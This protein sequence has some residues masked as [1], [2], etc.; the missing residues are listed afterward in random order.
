MRNIY[1]SVKNLHWIA[2]V[3]LA[4]LFLVFPLLIWSEIKLNSWS[5]G[6]LAQIGNFAQML[7]PIASSFWPV[8]VFHQ[9]VEGNARELIFCYRKGHLLEL[10]VY[11]AVY[12]ACMAIVFFVLSFFYES[13]WWEYLRVAIQSLFF[14]SFTYAVV[15]LIRS[16]ALGLMLS[17]LLELFFMLTRNYISSTWSIFSFDCLAK[18]D[19]FILSEQEK[20][21]KF[22]IL[23]GLSVLFWGIGYVRARKIKV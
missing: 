5:Q 13:V 2:L 20:V 18:E 4:V 11:G 12:V 8:F 22:I 9:Y 3:P 15:F 17:L 1:Y 19:V 14:L 21:D 23:L 6:N 7:L 10:F 16:T